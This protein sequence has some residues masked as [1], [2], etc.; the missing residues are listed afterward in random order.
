MHIDIYVLSDVYIYIYIYIFFFFSYY[1]VDLVGGY[2][3]AGDNVKFGLPMAFT[4]TMLSWGV[5]EYEGEIVGAGEFGHALEAIK[6]GTD[7]FIKA[8]TQP[9][10]LWAEVKS[11]HLFCKLRTCHFH[12]LRV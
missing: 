6:W 8:H 2:Y 11:E 5:I 9:N 4:I 12:A 7:Y 10:V 3:D 1:Q